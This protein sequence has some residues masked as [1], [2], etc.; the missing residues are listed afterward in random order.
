MQQRVEGGQDQRGQLVL[1]QHVAEAQD[2]AL[3]EQPVIPAVQTREVAEQRHIV[4]RFFPGFES[5]RQPPKPAWHEAPEAGFIVGFW[6]ETAIRKTTCRRQGIH[7]RS[8]AAHASLGQ[9]RDG[10]V[11]HAGR[12][13][14]CGRA[15]SVTTTKARSDAFTCSHAGCL[16][17]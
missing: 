4:Q 9:A 10:A 7:A 16:P 1:P 15:S 13:V 11:D 14:Q 8:A 12:T 3:V 5:R 17:V 2:G 6:G